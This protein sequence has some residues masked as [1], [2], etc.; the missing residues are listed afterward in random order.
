VFLKQTS[1]LL[2]I[3]KLQVKVKKAGCTSVACER[4]P[5]HT[6]GVANNGKNYLNK[7]LAIYFID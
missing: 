6:G 1:S 4:V 7:Y 2:Y 5:Q 3:S